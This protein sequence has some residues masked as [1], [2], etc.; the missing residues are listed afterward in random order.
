MRG[1]TSLKEC[2]KRHVSTHERHATRDERQELGNLMAWTPFEALNAATCPP[3]LAIGN[4]LRSVRASAPLPLERMGVARWCRACAVLAPLFACACV[5][6]SGGRV[7]GRSYAE[8]GRSEA[9]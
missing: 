1:C 6:A 7:P 2:Y 4:I 5:G 9:L 8:R 3:I